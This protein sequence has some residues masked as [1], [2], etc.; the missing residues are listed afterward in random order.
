M[1]WPFQQF[2]IIT[3]LDAVS[4]VLYF[5]FLHIISYVIFHLF[6]GLPSGF[7]NIGFH[8]YTN[9]A[10]TLPNSV[11]LSTLSQLTHAKRNSA[12][13]NYTSVSSLSRAHFAI[14]FCDS[15]AC[16]SILLAF[17]V[18]R[19]PPVFISQT[20]LINLCESWSTWLRS[21]WFA[22]CSVILMPIS[23]AF[24]RVSSLFSRDK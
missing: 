6:C 22:P 3:I 14:I 19:G 4:P 7:L 2:P 18:H 9:S 24:L 21:I 16:I 12:V 17:V 10:F 23:R 15:L 20:A 5:Q 1:F 13:Q 11:L 8:L